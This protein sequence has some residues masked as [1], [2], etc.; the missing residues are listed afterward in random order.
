M[1]RTLVAREGPK[2]TAEPDNAAGRPLPAVRLAGHSRFGLYTSGEPGRMR[3]ATLNIWAHHGDWPARRAALRAGFAEL[4]PDL[5]ALQETIGEQA[6]EIL[7][8]GFEIVHSARRDEDGMGIS[9][10]SRRPIDRVEEIPLEGSERDEGFPCTT[11]VATVGDTHFVNHFPSWKPEQELERERQALQAARRLQQLDGHVIVAG[12][13][14]ADPDAASMRFWLGRQSLDGTSVC[15]RDAWARIHPGR[16][17]PTFTPDENPL[18]ADPDWPF[19]EIDHILVRCGTHG[20]PTLPIVDCRRIF[21]APPAS[22]HFGL[23]ADLEET[24]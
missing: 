24:R 5:V 7:D 23:M 11:L 19:R 16:P 3:V 12:D 4:A 14:D 20:G 18:V 13:F 15:Y 2:K 22:D 21:D 1:P 6:R 17:A 10:A 9:I 8:A